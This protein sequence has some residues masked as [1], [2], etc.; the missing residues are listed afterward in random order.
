[1]T[2]HFYRKI[3][4]NEDEASIQN[5][6]GQGYAFRGKNWRIIQTG[7]NKKNTY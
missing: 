4:Q 6:V 5:F 3:A 1:M 7:T 2:G